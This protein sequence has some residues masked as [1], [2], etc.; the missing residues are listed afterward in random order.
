MAGSGVT[1][2]EIKKFIDKP[3]IIFGEDFSARGKLLSIESIN[4]FLGSRLK[5][6]FLLKGSVVPSG[7][8]M[9]EI[10]NIEEDTLCIPPGPN[11]IKR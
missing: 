3:V 5:A 9:N 11:Q 8:E 10:L 6:R 7:I 1:E 4:G 2:E